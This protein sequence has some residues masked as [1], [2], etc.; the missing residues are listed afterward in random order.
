MKC[1]GLGVELFKDNR[2]LTGEAV[3]IM[4]TTKTRIQERSKKS[5]VFRRANIIYQRA[6]CSLKKKLTLQPNI[7]RRSRNI[8]TRF[9]GVKE[10]WQ[11]NINEKLW[12]KKKENG[13]RSKRNRKS[14]KK[15]FIRIKFLIN[16]HQEKRCSLKD[17]IYF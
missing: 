13:K 4:R 17:M 16:T 2:W 12:F 5:E 10:N 15:T 14:K 3:H 1:Q 9:A 6:K 8:S 7:K 11:N